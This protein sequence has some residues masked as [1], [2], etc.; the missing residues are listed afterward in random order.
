MACV[1]ALS[2]ST[3]IDLVA[4]YRTQTV[5]A[6]AA[7]SPSAT[8]RVS[9]S[10][11]DQSSLSLRDPDVKALAF[12]IYARYQ[13]D[14]GVN[15]SNAE[16]AGD[17][18]RCVTSRIGGSTIKNIRYAEYEK[19]KDRNDPEREAK[20]NA[21]M[22]SIGSDGPRQFN[23]FMNIVDDNYHSCARDAGISPAPRRQ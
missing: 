12:A 6:V 19:L 23:E 21:Y 20:F 18:A 13:N 1:A 2:I 4:P 14:V 7:P 9:P 15:N 16:V 10:Q 11:A 5:A 8:N 17:L 22:N 3:A